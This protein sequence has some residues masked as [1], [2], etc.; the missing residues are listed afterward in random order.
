MRFQ[1]GHW[2]TTTGSASLPGSPATAD[3]RAGHSAVSHR[4]REA[5]SRLV[6]DVLS[7]GPGQGPF[8]RIGIE[9]TKRFATGSHRRGNQQAL[10][11]ELS[12]PAASGFGLSSS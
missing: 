11:A 2:A 12:R 8:G 9:H 6:A 4:P 7:T 3:I 1:N 5:D 10:L